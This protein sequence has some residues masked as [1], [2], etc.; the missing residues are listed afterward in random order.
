MLTA[1]DLTDAGCCA[2][3]SGLAGTLLPA[4]REANKSLA[5]VPVRCLIFLRSCSLSLPSSYLVMPLTTLQFDFLRP[6]L[7]AELETFPKRNPYLL[8]S[9]VVTLQTSCTAECHCQ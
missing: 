1:C 3:G 8:S 9:V 5:A 7:R 2:E 4:S 6:V